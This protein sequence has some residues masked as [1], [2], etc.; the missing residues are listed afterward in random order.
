MPTLI[1]EV[2]IYIFPYW[3][4][5]TQIDLPMILVQKRRSLR[6]YRENPKKQGVQE[7]GLYFNRQ[8]GF[9]YRGLKRVLK[10]IIGT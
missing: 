10:N 8:G 7:V 9:L 2:H 3:Y 4:S 1:H 6:H 5:L